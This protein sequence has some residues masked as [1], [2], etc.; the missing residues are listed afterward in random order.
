M[1]VKFLLAAALGLSL[2]AQ[3]TAAIP[4]TEAPLLII[5]QNK[6]QHKLIAGTNTIT[7]NRAPFDIEFTLNGYKAADDRILQFAAFKQQES[8]DFTS[9]G[10]K[11]FD[12]PYFTSN[13]GILR[14]RRGP[15][16]YLYLNKEGH[17]LIF[18]ENKSSSTADL[19]TELDEGGYELKWPIDSI[20]ENKMAYPVSAIKYDQIFCVA[21]FD[22]NDN[23]V[24]DPGEYAKIEINF[25]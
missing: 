23:K 15:Y 16:Q 12:I 24:V 14:P 17:H 19:V 9:D 5:T 11:T 3:H 7:L 6:V 13:S 21:F 10:K 8:L 20:F 4:P 22:K 18:Y 25:K 2:S 1:F